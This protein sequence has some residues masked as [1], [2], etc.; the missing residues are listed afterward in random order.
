MAE[1]LGA[2]LKWM[3]NNYPEDEDVMSL[4]THP[5]SYNWIK[6]HRL[7]PRGQTMTP[8]NID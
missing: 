7:E 3:Q 4:Y 1:Q 6:Y 8:V 2:A 5:A